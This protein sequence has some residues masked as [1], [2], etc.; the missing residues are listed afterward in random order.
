MPRQNRV[1]PFGELIATSERG[2]FLG[3]RGVLHD[4]A[5]CIQRPWQVKRWLLCLLDFRGRKRRVMTPRRYTELFFLDEAT[6]LAAGHRPCAECRHD[7]FLAFCEAWR[8]GKRRIPTAAVIDDQLHRERLASDRSKRYSWSTWGSCRTACSSS[9][10]SGEN[11][12][13]CSGKGACWSGRLEAI[14]TAGHV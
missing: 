3:N 13:T 8:S 4:D 10:M 14:A 1:T 6:G 12:P 7:R 5:G 11:A 9:A 2:T